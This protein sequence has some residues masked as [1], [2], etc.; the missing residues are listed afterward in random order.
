VPSHDRTLQLTDSETALPCATVP[1]CSCV[2]CSSGPTSTQM[3]STPT[4]ASGW[5][6]VGGK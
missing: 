5:G 6:V 1:C 4:L 3:P 2:W